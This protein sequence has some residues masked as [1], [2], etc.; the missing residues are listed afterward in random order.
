LRRRSD[1]D[2]FAFVVATIGTGLLLETLIQY[3]SDSGIK[4]FPTKGF[5]T[6]TVSIGSVALPTLQLTVLGST[7]AIMVLL[8]VWLKYSRLGRELRAVA[9]SQEISQLLGINAR[10]VFICAFAI[11][12]ALAALAG[13]FVAVQT[14]TISYSTGDS[15]LTLTFAAV[16]VGGIGSVPGAVVGGLSLGIGQVLLAGYLSSNFSNGF[17]YVMMA[18]VLLVRPTGLFK[19]QV[20]ARA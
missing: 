12:G 15:L 4:S 2:D 19:Q 5:P 13:T 1:S 20:V 8:G 7:V 6:G 18:A 10:Q 16:V 9:F 11:S 14:T 17:A 3:L